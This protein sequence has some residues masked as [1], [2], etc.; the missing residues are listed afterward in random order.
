MRDYDKVL[1]FFPIVFFPPVDTDRLS[2][3]ND[4]ADQ[5]HRLTMWS[6]TSIKLGPIS[7]INEPW[8]TKGD[9]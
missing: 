8:G 5:R 7:H 4:L 6:H 1:Y 3:I 9:N 2:G